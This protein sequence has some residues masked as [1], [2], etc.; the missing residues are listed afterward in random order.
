MLSTLLLLLAPLPGV[1]GWASYFLEVQVLFYTLSPSPMTPVT[2][3]P[4]SS[5][6]TP[7]LKSRFKLSFSFK[8]LI[9]LCQ[10]KTR[11]DKPPALA[12]LSAEQFYGS[13][14][15]FHLSK[16]QRREGINATDQHVFEETFGDSG[17]FFIHHFLRN[18]THW[19]PGDSTE[20]MQD[21]QAGGAAPGPQSGRGE[22][23]WAW[24]ASLWT[25]QDKRK[26]KKKSNLI[27][28]LEEECVYRNN[29]CF[30]K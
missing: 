10:E 24:E 2:A 26:G 11:F 14:F 23:P 3:P 29:F 1:P 20:G 8:F 16:T 19:V 27:L 7:L 9:S 18:T 22:L 30:G 5:N 28:Y 17:N 4:L 25:V 21:C 15:C 12:A 13:E 6:S